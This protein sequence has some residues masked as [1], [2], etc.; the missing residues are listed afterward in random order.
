MKETLTYVWCDMPHE[1]PTEAVDPGR[2]VTIDG[3]DYVYDLCQK[4]STKVSAFED[5]LSGVQEEAPPKEKRVRKAKT[6]RQ[7]GRS[8]TTCPLCPGHAPFANR[9]YLSNHLRRKHGLGIKAA[10]RKGYDV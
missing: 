1:K 7:T 8:G 3:H 2:E 5:W 6:G 4:C 9:Q 10:R